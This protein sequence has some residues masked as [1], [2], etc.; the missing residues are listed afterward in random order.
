[1]F[2][3]D[4]EVKGIRVVQALPFGLTTAATQAAR[5]IKFTPATKDDKPVSMYMQLEYNFNLY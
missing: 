1:V 3:S 5:R 4:G 2:S